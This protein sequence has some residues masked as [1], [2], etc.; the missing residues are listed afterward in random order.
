MALKN[1][2]HR[3]IRKRLLLQVALIVFAVFIL[4]MLLS[5][6]LIYKESKDIYLHAKNE[7]ITKDLNDIR[8][9]VMRIHNFAWTLEYVREHPAEIS[10]KVEDYNYIGGESYDLSMEFYKKQGITNLS[11]PIRDPAVDDALRKEPENV[12][13][14]VATYNYSTM[15]DSMYI[16]QF[17]AN[18]DRAYCLDVSEENRGFIYAAIDMDNSETA[19]F[20]QKIEYPIE[21]HPAVDEILN[22]RN[23][24]GYND[25]VFEI[26]SVD[27]NGKEYYIGYMPVVVNDEICCTI[28]ISFDFSPFRSNFMPYIGRMFFIGTAIILVFA[29]LLLLFL[30]RSAISP[31]KKIQSSVR[32]YILDKNSEV[33]TN[34]MSQITS[35][36]EFGALSGDISELVQ[37]IDRYTEDN[38]RL[39]SEKEKVMSELEFAAKI[40]RDMLPKDFPSTTRFDLYAAMDPAR[41]VGGDFYDF[42]Y[43]DDDTLALV[44]ADVSGKGVPASLFMMRSMI[45]IKN[46][47]LH[48]PSPAA[49]L[50]AVN[51]QLCLNN[52]SNMFVTV[53][54][55]I[56]DLRTGLL[57]AANAGHEY[58]IIK[59]PGGRYE[60]LKNKHSFVIGASDLVKYRENE[61]T[62]KPGTKL[63]V[64]TDGAPEAQN[65]AGDMFGIEGVCDALNRSSDETPEKLLRDVT[66]SIGDFVK[67]AEQFD[68]LTMMSVFY[69]GDADRSDDHP[70]EKA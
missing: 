20:V 41:E 44:M 45:M 35:E 51:K 18:Y 16:S 13:L 56:L 68:D 12:Q 17:Q 57:K 6:T 31:I 22:D 61:L 21:E 39:A 34:E 11:Y 42:F 10:E 59:N 32:R 53:W 54:L 38:I 24:D 8:E 29:A 63:F 5:G 67:D 46:I 19:I 4:V 25:V 58:P 36:N 28:C 26:A 48:N 55:G 37:E 66:A 70:D 3:K 49:I 15:I 1:P 47:A 40:Q 27:H 7:M 14:A 60:A 65:A 52:D 69:Y 9:N 2:I 33:V 43:I 30:H 62:L 23:G 50:T 64:Y